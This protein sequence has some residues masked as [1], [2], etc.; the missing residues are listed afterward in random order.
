MYYEPIV[1]T[2]FDFAMIISVIAGFF[3]VSAFLL[4][5]EFRVAGRSALVIF[6][7]AATNVIAHMA[8]SLLRLY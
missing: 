4:G 1:L 5:R 8:T 2:V 7:V 6:G 3:L